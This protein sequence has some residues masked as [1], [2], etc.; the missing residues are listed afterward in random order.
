MAKH[1]V[2]K[3]FLKDSGVYIF[4]LLGVALSRYVPDFK[5][6]IEPELAFSWFRLAMSAAVSFMVTFG[7]DA[8]GDREGK[9]QRWVRRAAFALSQGFMWEQL[10]G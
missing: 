2:A 5:A 7:F 9:R 1:T 6:G 3:N 10:I 8:G 4:C